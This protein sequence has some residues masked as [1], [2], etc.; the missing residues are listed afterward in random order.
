MLVS[1]VQS[2]MLKLD[3]VLFVVIVVD[4]EFEDGLLIISVVTV[5]GGSLIG[6]VVGGVVEGVIVTV[7]VLL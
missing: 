2:S 6:S 3:D 5:T 4:D 1:F 7:F